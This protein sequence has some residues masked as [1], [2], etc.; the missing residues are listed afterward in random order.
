MTVM[1]WAPY[2]YLGARA[3]CGASRGS[4][5]VGTGGS[6]FPKGSGFCASASLSGDGNT[7]VIGGTANTLVFTRLGPVWT[8]QVKLDIAGPVSLSKDAATALIGT[9]VFTQLN[10]AW[11]QQ[12]TLN[13]TLAASV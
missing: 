9:M 1:R 4:K 6:V 2:G 7:A 3:T 8:E 13:A 10:G 5:L 11:G 12:A